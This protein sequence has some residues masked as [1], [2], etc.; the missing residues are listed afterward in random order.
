MHNIIQP[1]IFIF[2]KM[3]GKSCKYMAEYGIILNSREISDKRGMGLACRLP[4]RIR[5]DAAEVIR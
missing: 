2:Q 1:K 4:G 3:A 5:G